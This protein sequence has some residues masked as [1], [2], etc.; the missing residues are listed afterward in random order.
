MWGWLNGP[1]VSAHLR[2]YGETALARSFLWPLSHR[3]ESHCVG[4]LTVVLCRR[5]K[6]G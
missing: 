2:V 3:L 6:G 1:F 5:P 4:T